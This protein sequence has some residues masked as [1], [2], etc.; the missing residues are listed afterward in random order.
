MRRDD[1]RR[2]SKTKAKKNGKRSIEKERKE[3]ED[4]EQGGTKKVQKDKIRQK[5]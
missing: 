2:E 1:L 4:K 3:R 5:E